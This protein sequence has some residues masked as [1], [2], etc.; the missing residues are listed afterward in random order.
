MLE[1]INKGRQMKKFNQG[2]FSTFGIVMIILVVA[3]LGYAGYKVYQDKTSAPAAAQTK[4]YT[5]T[6]KKFTFE[7]PVTWEAF[8][9]DPGGTDSL[10]DKPVT[11]P[12]W[13]V[14][15]RDVSVKPLKGEKDNYIRVIPNI[16]KDYV[17]DQRARKDRFHTQLD[18][19]I[20]NY[21][22]LYDKL[23]FKGDAESYVDHTYY[24]LHGDTYVM[25]TFRE[26]WYH[27]DNTHFDDKQNLTEFQAIVNSIKF[28][29]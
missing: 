17:A 29:D 15:S 11:L 21:D 5:D 28:T 8:N 1:R 4:T 16:T 27:G 10:G 2:G 6:A 12:D 24:V 18:G 14:T 23:A 25:F 19:K 9:P 26:N 7:Y 22:T 13:S 3:T 20:N